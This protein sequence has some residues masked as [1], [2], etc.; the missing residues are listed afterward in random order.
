MMRRK[1]RVLGAFLVLVAIGVADA[2]PPRPRLAIPTDAKLDSQLRR[3]VT[4]PS[5]SALVPLRTR[6]SKE[7]VLVRVASTASGD[8][9]TL[10]RAGLRIERVSATHDLVRGRIRKKDLSRLAALDVV[11]SVSPARRGHLRAGS[12]LTEGDAAANAPQARATGFDGTGVI[13][14]VISDGIDHVAQSIAT[15]NLAA[16][17]GLPPFAP[18]TC[19]AGAGDEGTAMLEIVHDL[20]PGAILRFSEGLSDK[21]QFVDSIDCL[22]TT[23]A[24]VIV[25]D[26][27]FF[28]EPFFEDGIV[29]E[30]VRDAV[31]AGVSFHSAAGNSGEVHYSAQFTPTATSEG[32][33]HDFGGGDLFDRLDIP[34]GRSLLCVLQW[35]DRFGSSANDYDLELWDLEATPNVPIDVS[36]NVQSGS[37]DPFEAVGVHNG[38]TSTG[39]VGLRVRRESGA[40]RRLKIFCLGA[41]NMAP[42]TTEGSIFGH[43][44]VPEVVA[45]AAMD[46]TDFGLNDVESFSSRGPVQI[47]F[48]SSQTRDKPDLTAF[49]GVATSI[50]PSP[51]LCFD[52][53]FGT[54][55]AAPH[56]AAAAAL[57]LSKNSCLTPAE[58]RQTLMENAVDILSTGFDDTSGAGRLD[59]FATV[60]APDDCDD[61]NP[62]TRDTCTPETGCENTPLD[63][64]DAC[65]DGNLCNGN[66]TCQ[67]GVCT[68]GTPLVCNDDSVCTNDSCSPAAGC[69][70]QN[71]CDDGNACS[72]DL[73]DPLVGCSH[74]TA[75]DGTP[76]P[77]T[78]LCN[79]EELCQTGACTPSAP[80]V[81]DD[82]DA[83]T[84]D[85]CDATRGCQFP[86]V[87]SFEGIACL[88]GAGLAA[89][90]CIAPGAVTGQFSKGCA[91]AARATDGKVRKQR[92]LLDAAVRKFN[93]AGQKTRRAVSRAKLSG[94]CGN[95]ISTTLADVLGRTLNLRGRI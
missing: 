65:P 35:N 4:G 81:C 51:G 26:I 85:Q 42:R 55:A 73:C 92:R 17:T 20:A 8:L 41:A 66:E 64:G 87:E 7:R 71:T 1:C 44:S 61:D 45:V 63:D 39:Q 40:T 15:G 62:C 3:R 75:P 56:S 6:G 14:G 83:C 30:A 21:L 2:A 12:V 91:L 34:P 95:A 72:T 22:R 52:P 67:A 5:T 31:A 48:P 28:D 59:A 37:Q 33:Y 24:N 23:G 11:R 27:G 79:G 43:P 77:D 93:K 25:D 36:A 50:C 54:S 69:V 38:G 78:D 82:G 29:A 47:S 53:F 76:C 13:V 89:P 19:A 60:T 68:P 86:E 57:L 9:R 58:V 80:L 84:T 10:R 49:D 32:E 46:A 88:C 94:E 74:A 18:N 16:G 70:F 90:G